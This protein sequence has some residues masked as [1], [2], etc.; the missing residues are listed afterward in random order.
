M[1]VGECPRPQAHALLRSP[2]PHQAFGPE[3]MDTQALLDP[4]MYRVP[5][6]PW[7]LEPLKKGNRGCARQQ[8]S[9]TSV[10][11]GNSCSQRPRQMLVTRLTLH[12]SGVCVAEDGAAEVRPG[13]RTRW[14]GD[15]LSSGILRGGWARREGRFAWLL[16]GASGMNQE[17]RTDIC[18]C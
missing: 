18:A 17:V 11:K 2:G 13:P 10:C 1:G 6:G 12:G 15:S 4:G 3:W 5:S 16:S 8:Q 7:L 14:G 9:W